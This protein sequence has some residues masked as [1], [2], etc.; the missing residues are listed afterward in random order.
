MKQLIMECND[1]E[2]VMNHKVIYLKNEFDFKCYNELIDDINRWK[3][4]YKE[5]KRAWNN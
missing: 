2:I 1:E 5:P 3:T 4:N